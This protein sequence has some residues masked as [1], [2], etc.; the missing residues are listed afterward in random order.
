MLDTQ[1]LIWMQKILH[2]KISSSLKLSF[3]GYYYII[4][5]NDQSDVIKIKRMDQ[6][7]LFGESDMKIFKF[8]SREREIDFVQG[9][10]YAPG[11]DGK[12]ILFDRV[13]DGYLINYDI[14]G[15]MYWMLNRLEEVENDK[16]D[17]YGRFLAKNSH[18]YKYKYLERP[19]VDEW[20]DFFKQVVVM[21]W[22]NM[23][24]LHSDF[25]VDV[26][27][28]V[29]IPGF[30]SLLPKPAMLRFMV[31]SII[32]RHDLKSAI[33]AAV[34]NVSKNYNFADNSAMDVFSWIMDQS[35]SH[36][37]TSTF[38]F[39]A[40]NSEHYAHPLYDT[41]YSIDHPVIRSLMK[42]INKRGHKI[43]LHPSYNTYNN[44]DRL[45]EELNKLRTVCNKDS[46]ELK[47]VS[48]RMHYLRWAQPGTL[49]ALDKAHISYDNTLGYADHAG[50]RCGTCKEYPAF[51]PIKKQNLNIRIRPLIAMEHTIISKGYMGL[52][53]TTLALE[54]ITELKD[55]C[56]NV[57]GTFSLLWHNNQLLNENERNIYSSFLNQ[58]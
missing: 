10:M 2:E 8:T 26:S 40:G 31:G 30:Y 5:N 38:Y 48:S 57:K 39:I 17:D 14:L 37:L 41:K 23:S 6:F 43:G 13:S 33:K 49:L 21:L 12:Q 44:E 18:A 55:A 20:I 56:K 1:I 52:G 16:L 32:K 54:K 29:D 45:R 7:Y 47:D 27:H 34:V 58:I 25:K 24:V 11:W 36:K 4:S 42:E 53:V 19:I 46:I 3:D 50:F 28:D 35:E 9:V 22:R 15:L 51:D